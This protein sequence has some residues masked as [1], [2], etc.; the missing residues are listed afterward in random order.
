MFTLSVSSAD[1]LSAKVEPIKKPIVTEAEIIEMDLS[2]PY[3]FFLFLLAAISLS[4]NF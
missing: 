3:P 4:S 1:A 2:R